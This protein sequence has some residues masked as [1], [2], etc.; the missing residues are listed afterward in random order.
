V[1]GAA[2]PG[3]AERCAIDDDRAQRR[4]D[5]AVGGRLHSLVRLLAARR[6]HRTA[7]RLHRAQADCGGDHPSVA[8]EKAQTAM[9]T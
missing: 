8:I 2:T 7:N 3:R 9:S 5:R 4:V 1:A 6:K